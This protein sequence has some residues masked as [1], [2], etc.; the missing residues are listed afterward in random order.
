MSL[1]LVR[2]Q[3][4]LCLHRNRVENYSRSIPSCN[5]QEHLRKCP[6]VFEY[7][8]FYLNNYDLKQYK[9]SLMAKVLIY[10]EWISVLLVLIKSKQW[11]L[12]RN[13]SIYEDHHII[14][15]IHNIYIYIYICIIKYTIDSVQSLSHYQNSNPQKTQK[16]LKL[17]FYFGIGFDLSASFLGLP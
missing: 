17:P 1:I 11:I 10:D 15:R 12:D 2:L 9:Q 5:S 3:L 13:F 6:I 7:D 16:R 8:W 14:N 4:L